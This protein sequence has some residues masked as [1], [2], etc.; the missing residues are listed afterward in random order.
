MGGLAQMKWDAVRAE[1]R[2]IMIGAALAQRT[3]TYAELCAAVRSAHLHYHSPLLTRLLVEI[4]TA[5]SEAGRPMLPAVVVTKQTGMPGA[6][7]FLRENDEPIENPDVYWRDA[8]EQV[9]SYWS[10]HDT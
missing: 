6:G 3:L 5:E 7:F 4:G 1:M 2:E 8:L 9:Y 10:E